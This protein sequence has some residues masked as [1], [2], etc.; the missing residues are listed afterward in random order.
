MGIYINDPIF[1]GMV[2]GIF[3]LIMEK[4]IGESDVN[5][6]VSDN[7]FFFFY[8]TGADGGTRCTKG[9]GNCLV[10]CVSALLRDVLLVIM[11][12]FSTSSVKSLL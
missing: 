9:G 4:S 1:I 7:L 8:S 10:L 6:S 11:F 5:I 3:V 2:D 12:S